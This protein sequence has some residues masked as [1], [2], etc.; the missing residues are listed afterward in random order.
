[1]EKTEQL[2]ELISNYWQIP[3]DTID[4]D[5]QLSGQHLKRFSSLRALRFLASIEDLFQVHIEDP[6]AINSFRDVLRLME[7]QDAKPSAAR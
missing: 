6:E 5:T 7:S 3:V 4:W 1:M 2:K